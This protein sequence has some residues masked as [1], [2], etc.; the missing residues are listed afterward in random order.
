MFSLTAVLMAVANGNSLALKI[1]PR[2]IAN[3]RLHIGRST[4]RSQISRPLGAVATIEMLDSVSGQDIGVHF[5]MLCSTITACYRRFEGM[6][7]G[8]ITIQR[9]R[10]V[11]AMH[12]FLSL[13]TCHVQD[14]K[15]SNFNPSIQWPSS[16]LW[17][18]AMVGHA[19]QKP[20]LEVVVSLEFQWRQ[21]ILARLSND[22]NDHVLCV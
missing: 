20:T 7:W 15:W 18:R 9:H 17:K 16:Q 4:P 14:W 21:R 11:T 6:F 22:A 10:V 3:P 1:T 19:C 12:A 2:S 13:P 5:R 8:N